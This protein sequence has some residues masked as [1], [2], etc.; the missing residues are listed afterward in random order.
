MESK[1]SDQPGATSIQ[2][3]LR[4]LPDAINVVACTAAS[5]IIL[6]VASWLIFDGGAQ[7]VFTAILAFFEA[8]RAV[9]RAHPEAVAWILGLPAL[10]SAFRACTTRRYA[11]LWVTIAAL[12]IAWITVCI[13]VMDPG[14]AAKGFVSGVSL[15]GILGYIVFWFAFLKRYS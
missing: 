5:A 10:F 15:L 14:D 6:A 7:R 8:W 9:A 4:R 13:A 2:S 12:V 11:L 3:P 1:P